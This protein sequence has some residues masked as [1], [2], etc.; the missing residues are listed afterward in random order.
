MEEE[1][2]ERGRG[3]AL[4]DVDT[5][6]EFHLEMHLL[7]YSISSDSPDIFAVFEHFLPL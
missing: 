5:C 3:M 1:E 7:S 4:G 6:V 2:E